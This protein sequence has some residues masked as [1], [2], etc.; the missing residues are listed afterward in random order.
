MLKVDP[1]VL[2]SAGA[3]FEAAGSD[4]AGLAP[5]DPLRS[6]AAGV[7]RL[8]TATACQSAQG[9]EFAELAAVADAAR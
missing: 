1:K 8:A 3:Q 7:P 2:S 9:S 4:L 6:A 5:D